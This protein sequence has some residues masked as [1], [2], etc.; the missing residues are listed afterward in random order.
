MIKPKKILLI[1]VGVVL[2]FV[3]GII[4]IDGQPEVEK[5]SRAS[6]DL[7]DDEKISTAKAPEFTLSDTNGDSLS[8]SDYKGRV[9]IINFWATWCAPCREEIP[10]FIKLQEKYNGE[11]AI[12]GI[13]VDQDGPRVVPPF[14]ERY[15]INY[16]VLYADGEIIRNYGGISGVPTTF[17]LDRNLVVQRYYVGYRP[18]YVFERDIKTFF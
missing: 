15:G 1:V 4:A 5:P 2:L 9:V 3:V 16:P 8:L 11:L 7:S 17:L 10:G 13:S 18:D 14:M 12:L 6:Q